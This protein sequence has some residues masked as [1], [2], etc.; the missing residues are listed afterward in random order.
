MDTG[1][2]IT[3]VVALVAAGAVSAVPWQRR[4]RLRARFG[5]E[6]DRAIAEHGD[7]RAAVRD[8]AERAKRH[9]RLQLTPL[10][11]AS[12]RQ[13]E[14]DWIR[15]QERFVDAPGEAVREGHELLAQLMSD[16][17]YPTSDEAQRIT[18]LSVEHA[19]TLDRYREARAVSER[20]AAGEATTEALRAAMVHYRA[21]FNELLGNGSAAPGG[22]RA[23]RRGDTAAR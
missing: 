17:G 2:I 1:L 13:Y 18:D 14:T 4:R 8:L 5:P 21:L 15:V 12:R 20:S 23:L 3:V 11:D 16:R 9:A 10:T 6:Y 22:P 7:R 19:G